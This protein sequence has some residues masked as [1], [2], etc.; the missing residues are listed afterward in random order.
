MNN[1]KLSEPF[2]TSPPSKCGFRTLPFI[3][4]T[5]TEAFERLATVGI[6]SNMIVYLTTEF[7]VEAV[8]A[9]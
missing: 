3:L 7:G 2:L 9:T 8:K 5:A 1:S 4:V 6:A